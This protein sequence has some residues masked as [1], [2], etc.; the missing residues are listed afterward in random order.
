MSRPAEVATGAVEA[1]ELARGLGEV[2]WGL[3]SGRFERPW[4]EPL[5]WRTAPPPITG[6]EARICLCSWRC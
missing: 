1:D 6:R 3:W 5:V 4:E 2:E